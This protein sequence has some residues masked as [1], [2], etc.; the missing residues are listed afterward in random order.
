MYVTYCASQLDILGENISAFKPIRWSFSFFKIGL[1]QAHHLAEEETEAQKQVHIFQ[2]T[3]PRVQ[4][5]TF[6]L[7]KTEAEDSRILQI[8]C[9]T[10]PHSAF[11]TLSVVVRIFLS[12]NNMKPEIKCLNWKRCRDNL[13]Q[14]FYTFQQKIFFIQMKY[15]M[16]A[17]RFNC[18]SIFN[19][20]L[21][22]IV[23][24]LQ[25]Q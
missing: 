17:C 13:A 10:I 25:I 19:K 5:L 12:E 1:A 4:S 2:G 14:K 16:K 18:L 8:C 6:H 23:L 24:F 21:L 11:A 22:G 20:H 7:Q 9:I 3:Q 15:Y